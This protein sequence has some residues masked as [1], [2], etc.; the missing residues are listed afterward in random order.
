MIYM[1]WYRAGSERRHQSP[2]LF[3]VAL[4]VYYA[5]AGGAAGLNLAICGT[6]G[7]L[8]KS[9]YLHGNNSSSVPPKTTFGDEA[10]N[11]LSEC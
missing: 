4:F 11:I 2:T 10:N 5:A 6:V 9:Q 1:F 8:K 7:Y 3:F